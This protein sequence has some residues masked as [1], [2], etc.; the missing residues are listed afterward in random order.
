[1]GLDMLF[2]FL[3][4]SADMVYPTKS[5]IRSRLYESFIYGHEANGCQVYQVR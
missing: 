3:R 1:M 2:D 4:G 5:N